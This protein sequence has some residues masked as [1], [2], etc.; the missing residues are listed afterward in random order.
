MAI[1]KGQIISE[2]K[3]GVLDSLKNNKINLRVYFLPSE[4]GQKMH[5]I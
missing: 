1:A 3:F 2:G 5:F 4:I